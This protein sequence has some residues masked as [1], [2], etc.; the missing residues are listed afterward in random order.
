MACEK[1]RF[2]GDQFFNFSLFAPWDFRFLTFVTL[3]E[4]VTSLVCILELLDLFQ[5]WAHGSF[6]SVRAGVS[7]WP[8][9]F[10]KS[11]LW[12]FLLWVTGGVA[13]T[14]KW[15]LGITCRN[16]SSFAFL[17][18]PHLSR[19]AS[20]FCHLF[21]VFPTLFLGYLTTHPF[22]LKSLEKRQ[23]DKQVRF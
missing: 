12:Q 16:P 13:K 21:I 7:F 11:L 14:Q 15:F 5:S 23:R 19:P 18:L 2:E 4:E 1:W 22:K 9:L 10:Q 20:V 17:N 6:V 8:V 3:R